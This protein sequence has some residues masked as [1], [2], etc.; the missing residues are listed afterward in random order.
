MIETFGPALPFWD[1]CSLTAWFLCEG[2]YSRTDMSGL[3]HYHRKEIAALDEMATPIDKQLFTDLIE[4]EKRLGPPEEIKERSSKTDYGTF[5]IEVSIG[6]GTRRKGFEKLRDVITRHRRAWAKKYLESYIKMRW[7]SEI[8]EA[9]KG[10]NLLL[11]GKSDRAPA[12]KRFA[13]MAAPATNHWFGGD[14]CGLYGAIREKCP[15]QP[16]HIRLMPK[17]VS[18]FTR[19]LFASLTSHAAP[20][21]GEEEAK[22]YSNYIEVL[23]NLGIKY[24]QLEEALGRPPSMKEIGER[25]VSYATAIHSDA[26]KVWEMFAG[27]VQKARAIEPEPGNKTDRL[28]QKQSLT[29]KQEIVSAVQTGESAPDA[30]SAHSPTGQRQPITV[31]NRKA[32]PQPI[33]QRQM[34]KEPEKNQSWWRRLLGKK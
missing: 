18:V 13:K 16:Q 23:A 32:I 25:F 10:Y 28:D 14:V 27:D 22:R 4:A 30:H 11:H 33:P 12:L 19:A 17:D 7:E 26:E 15:V 9:A 21:N 2:P 5:S 8:T 6:G 24:V 3:A 31:S 1:G 34:Q 20:F 29:Q